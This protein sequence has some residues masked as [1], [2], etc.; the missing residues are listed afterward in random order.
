MRMLH[1]RLTELSDAPA[2]CCVR[3]LA[4]WCLAQP[5]PSQLYMHAAS[6]ARCSPGAGPAYPRMPSHAHARSAKPTPVCSHTGDP[7]VVDGQMRG[8]HAP[9]RA[10]RLSVSGDTWPGALSMHLLSLIS[11]RPVRDHPCSMRLAETLPS[12][13]DTS[14]FAHRNDRFGGLK[15]RKIFAGAAPPHPHYK[16]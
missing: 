6:N 5:S 16:G 13:C 11:S 7:P 10:G 9:V 1:L 8:P 4:G 3:S 2:V 14:W 12:V 15:A